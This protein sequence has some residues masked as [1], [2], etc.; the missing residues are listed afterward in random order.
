MLL[1]SEFSPKSEP[2]ESTAGQCHR[3]KTLSPPPPSNQSKNGDISASQRI[4]SSPSESGTSSCTLAQNSARTS[5][6]NL[7]SPSRGDETPTPI[8]DSRRH[9][10]QLPVLSV[11]PIPANTPTASIPQLMV[12]GASDD[13]LKQDQH[14]VRHLQVPGFDGAP[15]SPGSPHRMMPRPFLGNQPRVGGGEDQVYGCVSYSQPPSSPLSHIKLPYAT[16][17]SMMQRMQG[18]TT[19]LSINTS[20]SVCHS[21][22]NTSL[23]RRSSVNDVNAGMV[24][25]SIHASTSNNVPSIPDGK[26]KMVDITNLKKSPNK[27]L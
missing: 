22:S 1:L 11:A 17:M 13:I 3:A 25:S 8:E 18:P 5:F 2:T 15:R 7:P 4:G 19:M 14:H 21:Q 26:S 10:K 23:C 24:K 16:S 12:E 27:P 9:Q 6:S 20:P